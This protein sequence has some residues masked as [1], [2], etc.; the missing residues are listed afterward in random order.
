MNEDGNFNY[1]T[2][3]GILITEMRITSALKSLE[4]IYDVWLTR[5]SPGPT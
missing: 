5:E 4:D 2:V 1:Y 3:V